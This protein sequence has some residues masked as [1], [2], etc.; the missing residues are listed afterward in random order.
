MKNLKMKVLS[1]GIVSTVFLSSTPVFAA[2]NQ[3][4]VKASN[5][6]V[7]CNISGVANDGFIEQYL[8]YG[9]TIKYGDTN[10]LVK[11]VQSHLHNAHYLTYVQITSTFD[12]DTVTALRQFQADHN[13]YSQS[14][15]EVSYLTFCKLENY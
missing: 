8:N 1:L 7:I 10:E 13:L 9:G 14:P 12:D 3:T 4:A 6:S 5:P 11:Q 2:T 15:Y